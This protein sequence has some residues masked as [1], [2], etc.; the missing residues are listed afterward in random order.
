MRASRPDSTNELLA[1]LERL[2]VPNA[3]VELRIVLALGRIAE[4]LLQLTQGFGAAPNPPKRGDLPVVEREDRL[5]GEQL[6]G[7][8]GGLPDPSAAHEVLERVDGEEEAS[9]GPE[10]LDERV[11]LVV[12]RAPVEPALDRIGQDNRPAPGE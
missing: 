6:S 4:D 9:I 1:F 3:K 10:A 8:P 11:D 2:G 7:E 5:D 12:I